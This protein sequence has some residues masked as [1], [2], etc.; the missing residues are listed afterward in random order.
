MSSSG[1]STGGDSMD[2]SGY[3][4]DGT[5]V[6]SMSVHYLALSYYS[7]LPQKYSPPRVTKS[8]PFGGPVPFVPLLVPRAFSG[9][10]FYFFLQMLQSYLFQITQW[11]NVASMT[12]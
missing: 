5:R 7:P 3:D 8:V 9:P 4:T 1:D 12:Q 10:L 11:E 6:I 2:T